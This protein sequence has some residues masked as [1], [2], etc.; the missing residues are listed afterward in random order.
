MKKNT[1]TV[2]VLLMILICAA[3]NVNAGS[4]RLY[5]AGDPSKDFLESHPGI[6][7]VYNNP[8]NDFRNSYEMISALVTNS[9]PYDVFELGTW[10]F[11]MHEIMQKGFCADLSSSSVIKAELSTMHPSILAQVVHQGKI[12]A[13][14]KS[15]G[16]D[17]YLTDAIGWAAAGL[18]K[19]DVPQ[20]FPEL[21][22]FLESWYQR[23]Q[24]SPE[25]SISV[26]NTW[27]ASVYNNT[28]YA[29]W[30]VQE[31]IQ[32][33]LLQSEFAE[34]P[35][36]FDSETFMALLNRAKRVGTMLFEIEPLPNAQY[37]LID[38][39]QGGRSNWPANV[40]QRLISMRLDKGQP[41]LIAATLSA[42]A[43][44]ARAEN[45]E[46]AI[47]FLEDVVQQRFNKFG[48][49]LFSRA[50][51]HT[52]AQAIKNPNTED[53]LRSTSERIEE[54]KRKL[55]DENLNAGD[56]YELQV[57]L[58][59]YESMLQV[60]QE[61]AYILSPLS[62]QEYQSIVDHLY[63]ASPGPF[64]IATDTGQNVV[65]LL[66]RFVSNNISAQELATE[67]DRIARLVGLEG[68]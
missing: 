62:L 58:S 64:F 63:F 1:I 67:L 43:A 55:A 3:L 2:A 54:T 4:L 40:T 61:R 11:D 15:I 66:Q 34:I 16:C 45:E 37:Q 57:S 47:Q 51:L 36:R 42:I 14:P 29:T 46:F 27:D 56:R 50:M 26:R 68:E 23:M 13:I 60:I 5:Y 22:D 7:I 24:T 9:F 8:E 33:H 32:S 39:T 21:L 31:L 41:N 38:F 25:N 44:Y 20:S 18:T 28:S 48:V 17:L 53:D 65:T 12:L 35:L 6:D 10:K 19:E 52:D 30:L 49:P 59:R